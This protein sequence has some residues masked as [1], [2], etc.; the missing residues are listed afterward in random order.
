ALAAAGLTFTEVGEG[1]A[2]LRLGGPRSIDLLRKGTSL[3]LHPRVFRPGDCAQTKLAQCGVLLH[4]PGEAA[5]YDIF[6]ERSFA[7][8]LWLWLED[9]ALEFGAAG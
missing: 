3:N 1:R 7:E 2:A 5:V 4:R 8:Y 9:A 6:C